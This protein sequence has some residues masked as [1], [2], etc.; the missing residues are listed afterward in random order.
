MNK[1][2][3]LVWRWAHA[4]EKYKKLYNHA[5]DEEWLAYIRKDYIYEEW[6]EYAMSDERNGPFGGC[7]I[8]V[9]KLDN[10]DEIRV[11]SH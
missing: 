6:V 9:H 8:S 2:P 1:A 7:H 3:I 10:G 4:P 5:G 11:G